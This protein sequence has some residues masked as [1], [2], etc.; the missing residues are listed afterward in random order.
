MDNTVAFIVKDYR[1]DE[2]NSREAIQSLV[3]P[4]IGVPNVPYYITKIR[5]YLPQAEVVMVSSPREFLRGEREDLD[6]Y[7]YSAE[8][9]SAWTLVYPEYA[10]AVPLPDLIKIPLAYPLPKGDQ[11]MVDFINGWLLLKQKDE[12]IEKLFNHWILGK[13]ADKKEPRW[14]IIRN[15]LGWVD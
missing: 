6:A 15:V 12:T 13:G 9:G 10:V 3:A 7:A 4:K 8:A 2:F 14:S 1:R 11:D 5:D